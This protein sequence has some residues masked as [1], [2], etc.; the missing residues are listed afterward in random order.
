MSSKRKN[1]PMKLSPTMSKPT[2]RPDDGLIRP[3]SFN[4]EEQHAQ[5]LHI[6]VTSVHHTN[7]NKRRSTSLSSSGADSDSQSSPSVSKKARVLSSVAKE[8]VLDTVKEAV[9][10]SDYS[11]SEKQAQLSRMIAELQNLQQNLSTQ[12]KAPVSKT[13]S[14][15]SLFVCRYPFFCLEVL[16]SE[17]SILVIFLF[18]PGLILVRIKNITAL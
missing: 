10:G 1:V 11:L 4:M 9:M 15:S 17:M 14:I 18:G 13:I 16:Y 12:D 5:P 8:D 6:D 7:G 2:D 3:D